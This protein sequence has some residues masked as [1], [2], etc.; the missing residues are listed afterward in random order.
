MSRSKKIGLRLVLGAAVALGCGGD[1]DS[2]APT[3]PSM[4]A[5]S[6][7]AAPNPNAP[8][9]NQPPVIRH[10][11]FE[12]ARPFATEPI[13]V[14]VDW[15]DPDGDPVELSYKW[16]LNGR[17]LRGNSSEMRFP[18]ARKNQR[19]A[20]EVTANDGY[21]ASRAEL[22]T[23]FRNRAPELLSI[24][25]EPQGAIQAGTR[26]V[27]RPSAADGDGDPMRFE[28]E[29]RVNGENVGVEGDTLS[30]DK[31][32]R[33]DRVSVAVVV[34]DGQDRSEARPG[35]EIEIANSP[36][37]IVSQPSEAGLDGVFRYA[38]EVV[39][40]DGDRGF[41]YRLEKAPDGMEIDLA[42]G[43]LVWKPDP[44]QAGTFPIEVVVEDRKGGVARQHFELESGFTTVEAP[45][46]TP[47]AAPAP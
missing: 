45:A 34:G 11:R 2:T 42:S 40:P 29:W 22:E 33:G 44:D 24:R 43:E 10:M 18:K 39:D 16:S 41:R 12:P 17:E 46:E 5:A 23:Q 28:Y 3:G 9:G 15:N 14:E 31:L 25:I 8:L 36:P 4:T 13:R 32:R 37:E 27:A 38:L 47:P 35:P 7:E 30:T 6:G 26:I 21:H 20:V 19:L 1:P